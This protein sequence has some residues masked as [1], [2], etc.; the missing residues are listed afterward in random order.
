M[1]VQTGSKRFIIPLLAIREFFQ[2]RKED[3]TRTMDGDEIVKIRDELI[4]IMR[5]HT[6]FDIQD[7]LRDLTEGI[8]IICELG[9]ENHCLY[10][11]AILGQQKTVIK[12]IPNYYR[13]AE[14]ISGFTILG[15]GNVCPILDLSILFNLDEV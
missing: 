2:P 14:G 4:P 9:R 13:Q 8:L 12:A 11:D 3:I 1:L 15:D 6:R 7:G 10:V 5:L